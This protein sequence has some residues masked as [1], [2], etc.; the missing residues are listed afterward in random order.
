M[1]ALMRWSMGAP[2][3]REGAKFTS[4]SHGLRVSSSKMSKPNSWKQVC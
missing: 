4:R 1:G 2:V 3:D